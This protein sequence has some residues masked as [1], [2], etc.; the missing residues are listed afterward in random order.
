MVTV[1]PRVL[2]EI[3]FPVGCALVLYVAGAFP[4]RASK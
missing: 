2:N 3:L 1:L 4:I